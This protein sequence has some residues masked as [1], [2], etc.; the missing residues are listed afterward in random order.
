[1]SMPQSTNGDIEISLNNDNNNN[2]KNKRKKRFIIGTAA[3]YLTVML[4]VNI[5]ILVT[6]H[7]LMVNLA[8]KTSLQTVEAISTPSAF[9][10]LHYVFQIP[11]KK[12]SGVDTVE[13]KQ[14]R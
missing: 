7:S 13:Q 14:T 11:D 5:T 1:M 6:E 2:N 9:K 12:Q 10:L 3:L 8:N 4:T